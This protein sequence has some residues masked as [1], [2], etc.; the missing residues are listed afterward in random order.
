MVAVYKTLK[1]HDEAAA[2]SYNINEE[3]LIEN[4]ARGIREFLSE[5]GLLGKKTL[6]VVGSGNNGAD[7]LALARMIPF[8]H[9]FVGAKPK[10]EMCLAQFERAVKLDTSFVK[11]VDGFEVIIDALIGSG[12]TKQIEGELKSLVISLNATNGVKIAVDIPSGV[13]DGMGQ[14]DT[15]FAA[16]FTVTFGAPKE[17]LY[18]DYAKDYVGEIHIKELGLPTQKYLQGFVPSSFL[19]EKTDFNPPVRVKKN[20]NKGDFGHLCIVSGDM[21]GASVIAAKAALRFGVG[22][23]SIS[24]KTMMMVEP[25]IITKTVMVANNTTLIGQGL[26][27]VYADDEILNMIRLSNSCVVDADIFKKECIKDILTIAN[28][29]IIFTPHPKELSHLL[30]LAMDIDVE[31]DEIQRYKFDFARL[32]CRRFPNKCFILK[33]ANTLIAENEKLIIIPHGSQVLAKAGSGDALAGVV[34][35]LM[36]QGYSMFDAALNGVSAIAFA[37]ANYKGANYS[38]T[39]DE[40]LEELKWL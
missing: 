39:I 8:A 24:S 22:L 38:L 17:S 31:V 30:R 16:D 32:I 25:Q 13:R 4:A 40:L 28:K 23:V 35:A 19:F 26:G 12:A 27:D 36:A 37:A 21:P 9:L 11:S 3:M 5:K 6:I 34:A 2:L 14:D 18:L 1:A 10:S 20:C 7:G 29:R 33:G 15:V